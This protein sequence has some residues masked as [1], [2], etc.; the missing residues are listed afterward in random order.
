MVSSVTYLTVWLRSF[1]FLKRDKLLMVVLTIAGKA[2]VLPTTP[3]FTWEGLALNSYGNPCEYQKCMLWRFF[4]SLQ[5][6]CSPDV[7]SSVTFFSSCLCVV[8]ALRW[9]IMLT[10]GFLCS[11]EY[12]EVISLA[13]VLPLPRLEVTFKNE[14]TGKMHILVVHNLFFLWSLKDVRV[15]TCA[16]WK[17][18]FYAPHRS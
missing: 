14:E 3:A 8:I 9:K 15:G 10:K 16:W 1:F 12:S 17:A 6:P 4:K 18:C 5:T 7:P 11:K 13:W 2:M